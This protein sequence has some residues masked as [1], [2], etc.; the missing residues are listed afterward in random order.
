MAACSDHDDVLVPNAPDTRPVNSG[1]DRE[2]LARPK[3]RRR[4]ARFLMDL[5]SQPVAG[6]VEKAL[7][8]PV[9]DLRGIAAFRKECLYVLVDLS[10]VRARL[11]CLEGALLAAQAGFPQPSLRLV[12]RASHH[13]AG[14]IAEIAAVCVAR[15]NVENEKLIGKERTASTLMRI[16]GQFAAGN[17]GISSRFAPCPYN[18]YLHF[19]PQNLSGQNPSVP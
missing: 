3:S 11:Q 7:P 8:P 13:R 5:K 6:S 15:K 14:Q 18:R 2:H 19:P 4:K 1:L 10:S 12:C 16:A 17:D 9:L